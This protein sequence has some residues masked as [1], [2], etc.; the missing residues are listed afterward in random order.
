MHH[1]IRNGILPDT[2]C[3]QQS[4]EAPGRADEGADHTPSGHRMHA[5]VI[6]L[7]ALQG[8]NRRVEGHA[9]LAANF[10]DRKTQQYRRQ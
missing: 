2:Q 9:V 4:Q 5:A 10:I 1:F 3:N 7:Y 8:R 6:L